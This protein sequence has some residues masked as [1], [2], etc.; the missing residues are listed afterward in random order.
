MPLERI[1]KI[2]AICGLSFKTKEDLDTFTALFMDLNNHTGK[3]VN[4]GFTPIELEN[5]P[6]SEHPLYFKPDIDG[7]LSINHESKPKEPVTQGTPLYVRT[8][9]RKQ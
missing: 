2:Q 3:T 4:R 5:A 9:N 6:K 7:Q 8:G 1:L